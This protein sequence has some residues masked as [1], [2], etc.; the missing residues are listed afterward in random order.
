MSVLHKLK[1]NVI[2]LNDIDS[3]IV[4]EYF[5]EGYKWNDITY[6]S[7][8]NKYYIGSYSTYNYSS[9]R[10]WMEYNSEIIVLMRISTYGY[11]ISDPEVIKMFDIKSKQFIS[12][13]KEELYDYYK[14][15]IKKNNKI[16]S[17][18]IKV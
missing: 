17:K 18:K 14:N 15:K 4:D 12:G 11:E 6:K 10:E 7:G 5:E 8:N 9:S 16:K 3:I 13:T 1:T 2:E